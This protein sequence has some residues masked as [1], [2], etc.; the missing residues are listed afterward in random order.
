MLDVEFYKL[1]DGLRARDLMS[2]LCR[3]FTVIFAIFTTVCRVLPFFS[4]ILC[5]LYP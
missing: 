3:D 5:C 4:T 2:C 1:Y